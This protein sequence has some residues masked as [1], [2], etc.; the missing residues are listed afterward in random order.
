MV[1]GVGV[2]G[3]TPRTL[4]NW[5]DWMSSVFR[6]SAPTGSSSVFQE[7]SFAGSP[8]ARRIAAEAGISGDRAFPNPQP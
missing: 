2:R 4:L 5:P 8:R 7:G 3:L 6:G 1:S